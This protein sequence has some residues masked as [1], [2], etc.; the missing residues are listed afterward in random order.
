MVGGNSVDMRSQEPTKVH[1]DTER[2]AVEL[3]RNAAAKIKLEIQITDRFVINATVETVVTDE[4]RHA[5]GNAG[6][7]EAPAVFG[8]AGTAAF[9]C[10]TTTEDSAY[11]SLIPPGRDIVGRG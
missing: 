2:I 4:I 9:R 6:R 3:K 7:G 1:A 10:G 8:R 5:R 11:H